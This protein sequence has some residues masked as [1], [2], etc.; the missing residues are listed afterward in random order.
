MII[1]HDPTNLLKI[2][3]TGGAGFIGRNLVEFLLQLNQVIIYDNLS[4]SS[5]SDTTPLMDKGAKFV[6]GDVLDYSSL[7]KSSVGCDLIIH[8]AAKSG[9]E[10]S[11]LNPKTTMEV[12]VKGTENIMRCCVENKIK[13]LIFASSA[14]VYADSEMPIDENSQT[15]PQSPYGK[16]KLEAE[17]IIKKYSTEFEIDAICLRMFN[18]YGKRQNMKY[19]GVIS[20]FISNILENKPI[21]I[22]G[23]GEQTRDFISIYDVIHAFDCAIKKIKDKRGKPYNI[24]YG[25]S[26]SVNELAEILIGISRKEIKIMHKENTNE[27]RYSKADT[28]LAKK[29]LGFSAKRKL[30]DELIKLF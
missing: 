17:K 12:N 8:L 20:K 21:Q 27:V 29:E 18:V 2:L 10:D 26:T 1:S 9:V 25:K 6:N 23:D 14:S 3:V 24:G 16:S 4:N 11:I 7:Q 15:D 19:A 13:K 28:S 22:N 5:K 30:E